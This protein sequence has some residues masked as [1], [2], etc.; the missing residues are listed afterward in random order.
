M[1]KTRVFTPVIKL[2]PTVGNNIVA[3]FQKR[4]F[5]VADALA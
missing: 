4:L 2:T 1:I 5:L 3:G